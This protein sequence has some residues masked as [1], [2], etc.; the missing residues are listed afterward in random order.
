MGANVSNG[1]APGAFEI[2]VSKVLQGVTAVIP[3]TSNLVIAGSPMTKAQMEQK[4]QA[5]LAEYD[6]I[7]TARAALQGTLQTAKSSRIADHEFLMQLHAALVA[8]F[9]RQSPELQKFGYKP[10][11]RRTTTAAEKVSAEAK[12]KVTRELRHVMGS[13]QKLEVKSGAITDV[14]VSNG[15]VVTP[16]SGD[17]PATASEQG[18]GS[19][20]TAASDAA[21]GQQGGGQGSNG[22]GK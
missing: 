22:T 8:L 18:S 10:M 19:G 5:I 21:T 12:R 6:A 14:T 2:A 1:T 11:K 16:P 3:A 4:L 7:R 20:S 9:G 15:E 17:A 13:R